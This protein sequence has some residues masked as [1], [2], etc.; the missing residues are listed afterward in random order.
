MKINKEAYLLVHITKFQ[1]FLKNKN[2]E[3]YDHMIKNTTNKDKIMSDVLNKLIQDQDFID[4]IKNNFPYMITETKNKYVNPF[5][6]KSNK[7][8]KF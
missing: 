5:I 1:E 3:L 4:F 2:L 7:K 8:N 6:S